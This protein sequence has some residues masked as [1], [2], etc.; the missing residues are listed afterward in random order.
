MTVDLTKDIPIERC[1]F[2]V[3]KCLDWIKWV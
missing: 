3:W 1:K 2:N